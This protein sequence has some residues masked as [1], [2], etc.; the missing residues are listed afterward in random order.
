MTGAEDG[1]LD[2]TIPEYIEYKGKI[3]SVTG[4][5]DSA[6][7]KS[8]VE[9]VKMANNIET[10]GEMAFYGSKICEIE[11]PASVKVLYDNT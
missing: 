8:D 9:Y 4:I 3:L 2:I 10:I 1:Y 7:Y 6:F 11:I 5:G